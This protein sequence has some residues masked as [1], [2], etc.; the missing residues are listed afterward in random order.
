MVA[1]SDNQEALENS[2]FSETRELIASFLLLFLPVS[3]LLTLIFYAFSNQTQEYELQTILLREELALNDASG[4]TS[5]LFEQK[6]S[7][8][9]V[10]A[11]GEVLRSYLHEQ[12][13]KNWTH[14]AR[15][16]SLLARRKPN[17][18]Q[19]RFIDHDGKEVVRINNSDRGQEIVP[20][21]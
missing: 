17:Y 15:E 12:S 3:L 5:L 13:H 10:V 1:H 9:M 7:D 8:L 14:V 4:L 19:V 20:H 21:N 2:G 11:E 6:L 18:V 16:F